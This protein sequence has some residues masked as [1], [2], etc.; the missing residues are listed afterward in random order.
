MKIAILM[1]ASLR[2]SLISDQVIKKLEALGE[3]SMNPSDKTDKDTIKKVVQDADIAVTSW[4]IPCLD[5]EI[6]DCAPKLTMVAH[7]AGSVKG[8]VSEELYARGIK[9]IS[10]ARILSCGVSETVLGLTIAACKNVFAFNR[11]I[12][13][14][15][16]VTDY[17]VVRELY[18]ITIGVVGCGFAGS[19][20]I[21]LLQPFGVRV[22][23][24]DPLVPAE[25]IAGMGAVKTD[26]NTLLRESDVVSLHAPN[27]ESTRHMINKEALAFMKNNAILINTARGALIDEKAL[28]DA[29]KAGKLQY[30]CLDVTDPEPPAADSE[31]RKIPN[32][33]LTPHIA[34]C[35]NNGK[36]RIGEH[37][38]EEIRRFLAGKSLISEVTPEMLSTI[39]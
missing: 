14:G 31:L 30:A 33:I 36:L 5:R 9:V 28:A 7:A 38:L 3:V 24:F 10:S 35:A 29:M 32:C 1:S 22:L 2:P 27:L 34:G 11:D 15:G 25:K 6:L 37:V 20:Y 12:H 23:A 4:G 18:G 17:S 21:E 26:L 13:G 19:H 39:A 8:L 16:W